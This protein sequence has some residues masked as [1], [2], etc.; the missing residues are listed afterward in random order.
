MAKLEFGRDSFADFSAYKATPGEVARYLGTTRLRAD[1]GLPAFE[2]FQD[3][4]LKDPR[5]ARFMQ[6]MNLQQKGIPKDI[7][8]PIGQFGT[9]F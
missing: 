5:T 7:Q 8:T 1:T 6:F 9:F 4:T 2:A 3:D